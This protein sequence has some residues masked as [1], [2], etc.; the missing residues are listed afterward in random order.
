[1][2]EH[3]RLSPTATDKTSMSVRVCMACETA[4]RPPNST[5][6]PTG[7]APPPAVG[8]ERTL[9]ADHHWLWGVMQSV[10]GRLRHAHRAELR[11]ML[12]EAPETF[13]RHVLEVWREGGWRYHD[14]RDSLGHP[15]RLNKGLAT[16]GY[17]GQWFG[18]DEDHA[19]LHVA[20]LD[21]LFALYPCRCMEGDWCGRDAL[22]ARQSLEAL[23][24]YPARGGS[25]APPPVRPQVPLKPVSTAAD[26]GAI[27]S[28]VKEVDPLK[29][30]YPR[31][32]VAMTRRGGDLQPVEFA[33]PVLTAGTAQWKAAYLRPGGRLRDSE[34]ILALTDTAVI[35]YADS[36]KDTVWKFEDIKEFRFKSGWRPKMR[37][38][39]LLGD[40]WE[41]RLWVEQQTAANAEYILGRKISPSNSRSAGPSVE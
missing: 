17:P 16:G 4:E 5:T 11:T 27:E 40:S 13:M 18:A 36:G 3:F 23:H 30:P 26:T 19:R 10:A 14:W 24:A 15:Y 20:I 7:G 12:T 35:F 28:K 1:M 31:A 38:V 22:E 32:H 34:G 33:L 2:P 29:L 6:S 41:V 8:P 39:R 21:R 9:C 25:G 37:K